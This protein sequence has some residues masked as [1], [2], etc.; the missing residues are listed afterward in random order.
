VSDDVFF[1]LSY[2]DGRTETVPLG[3]DDKLLTELQALPGFDNEAFTRAMAVSE[4]GIS[5]LW[6]GPPL[7]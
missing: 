6:N 1:L 7:D 4:T 3:D 2:G 5:V